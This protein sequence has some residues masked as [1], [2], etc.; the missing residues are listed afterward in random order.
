M[1]K[2]KLRLFI[3]IDIGDKVRSNITSKLRDI[4][5]LSIK[6]RVLKPENIHL[7]IKFL[8]SADSIIVPSIID[9]INDAVSNTAPFNLEVKGIGAFPNAKK[10]RI[11]W[12][13]LTSK[14]MDI[15]QK[16]YES[17][18]QR[19]IRLSFDKEER[20]FKPHLTLARIKSPE[21]NSKIK[22][23]IEKNTEFGFGTINVNSVKLMKS[24]LLTG[25]AKYDCISE[26]LL[27]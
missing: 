22:N 4:S 14:N 25:G 11:I 13:G 24:T 20:Q 23:Y 9:N 5:R 19:M 17:I 10:S 27:K 12:A 7:T 3:A 1:D 6:I 21:K 26:L 16:L 15:F 8:G 2:E 18:E